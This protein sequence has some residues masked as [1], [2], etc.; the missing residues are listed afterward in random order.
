MS[1]ASTKWWANML[2]LVPL[3]VLGSEH[4]QGVHSVSKGT[5]DTID[6]LKR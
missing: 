4:I 5:M 1:P 3:R 2:A 6:S